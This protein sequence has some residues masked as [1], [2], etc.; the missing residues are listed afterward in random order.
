MR[1]PKCGFISFDQVESCSKCG[2]NISKVVALLNGTAVSVVPPRFLQ[3]DVD[4]TEPEKTEGIDESTELAPEEDETSMAEDSNQKI[5]FSFDEDAGP[6]ENIEADEVKID[7]GMEDISL[8][9]TVPEETAPSEEIDLGDL[10]D[11]ARQEDSTTALGDEEP[12]APDLNFDEIDIS[13]LAPSEHETDDLLLN[14][15][16]AEEAVAE[17]AVAEMS[18]EEQATSKQGG[19]GLE[20]LKL[21]GL[22]LDPSSRP[23]QGDTEPGKIA[24]AVKT[25]TA[26]DDFEI[27]LGELLDDK[28]E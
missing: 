4:E 25:G 13:D 11:D 8:E 3:F 17:E 23:V 7:L 2:K 1:C 15:T 19:I 18:E 5:E 16:V 28:K 27:D 12:K 20:D 22:D 10:E 21:D 9:E 14:E 24:S 26:L 6:E